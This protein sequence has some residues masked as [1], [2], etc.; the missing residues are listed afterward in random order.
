M[1]LTKAEINEWFVKEH[2]PE[3]KKQ[4]GNKYYDE[5]VRLHK[6]AEKS[7]VKATL[8]KYGIYLIGKHPNLK[9]TNGI[10]EITAPNGGVYEDKN[11][12]P[13]SGLYLKVLKHF[14]IDEPTF[15]IF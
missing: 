10:I 15:K 7:T 6:L 12:M 3:I 2:L 4:Y 14:K 11:G 1:P 9:L 5:Y 8:L 13:I